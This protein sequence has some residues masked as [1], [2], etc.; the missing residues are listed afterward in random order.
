MLYSSV[1]ARPV[2]TQGLLAVALTG[3]MPLD[4]QG[5]TEVAQEP[6]AV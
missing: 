4:P 5:Q 1:V 3:A 6:I 2:S